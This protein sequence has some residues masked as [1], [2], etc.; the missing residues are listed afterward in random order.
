MAGIRVDGVHAAR[1]T[2]TCIYIWYLVVLIKSRFASGPKRWLGLKRIKT[3]IFT[4][5]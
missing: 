1:C 5:N 4:E 2:E 3:I